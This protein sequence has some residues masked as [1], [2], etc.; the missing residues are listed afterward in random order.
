MRLRTRSGLL[1]VVLAVFLTLGTS[2]CGVDKRTE[3]PPAPVELTKSDL[4]GTWKGWAGS[5]VTLRAD[6]TA[7][8]STLDGQEFRFD[9]LWRM[10]GDG[11]WSLY[12]PGQY[13]AGNTVGDGSVVHLEVKPSDES[14]DASSAPPSDP[15]AEERTGDAPAQATWDLGVIRKKGKLTLFFLTSDP[16]LRDYYYLQKA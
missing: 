5:S 6:H 7:Q 2:A 14:P 4:L 12:A 3:K 15:A 9:D 16:D 13:K 10:T 11:K 8:V 1:P